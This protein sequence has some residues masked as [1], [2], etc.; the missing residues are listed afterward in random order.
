MPIVDNSVGLRFFFDLESMSIALVVVVELVGM[1]LFFAMLF[2]VGQVGYSIYFLFSV[3]G[4]GGRGEC[5]FRGYG[6]GTINKK[7]INTSV[8]VLVLYWGSGGEDQ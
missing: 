1:L 3:W 4:R 2:L 8:V 6:G 7:G 5:D